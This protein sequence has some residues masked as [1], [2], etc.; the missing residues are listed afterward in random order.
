VRNLVATR[1]RPCKVN[2]GPFI[3]FPSDAVSSAVIDIPLR[4]DWSV[5][6]SARELEENERKAFDRWMQSVYER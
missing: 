4:P 1:R 6:M 2:E 5:H 3:R